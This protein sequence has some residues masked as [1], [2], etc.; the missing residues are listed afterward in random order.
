MACFSAIPKNQK[1]SKTIVRRSWSFQGQSLES[2]IFSPKKAEATKI[3]INGFG[4]IGRMVFQAWTFTANRLPTPVIPMIWECQILPGHLRPEP[5][6][7]QAGRGGCGWHVHWC[8][9]FCLSNEAACLQGMRIVFSWFQPSVECFAT[10]WIW[11]QWLSE[12]FGGLNV[13]D[14]A[15]LRWISFMTLS[16][17]CCSKKELAMSIASKQYTYMWRYPAGSTPTTPGLANRPFE[18]W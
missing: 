12:S 16:N 7:N 4:R 8:G 3:G 13:W 10:R 17:P 18:W 11:I 15:K 14:N 1:T 9:I 2:E 5:L 6:G